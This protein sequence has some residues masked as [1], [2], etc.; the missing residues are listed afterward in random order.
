MKDEFV[1]R[2]NFV[3]SIGKSAIALPF[4]GLRLTAAAEQVRSAAAGEHKQA[5]GPQSG[6]IVLNVRDYGATGDGTTKD[7]L[8]IQQT[9]ERCSVFGGGEV[10]FPAGDYLSG[11]LEL[12]SNVVLRV[13]QGA[14]L[15]GSP[16][17]AD[18]PLAQ[19]RWEGR[20]IKGYIGFISA[21]DAENIG[22]V[23]P[24]RIVGS[25]AVKGRVDRT[26]Q[27]RLPALLEFTNCRNVNVH[28]CY[29]E[30]FGMWSIHPTYCENVTFKN[31]TVKSGA[32]GIDVDSC[33][34]VL[35][36]GCSFDTTDD[37]ISLKSGRG[38]EGNTISR[39]T[40]NV[41]IANCTFNDKT[42]ACIGIGSETSGGIRNVHVDHC[43][44]IGART[45]AIYIK[46]RRGRGAFIED[47]YMNDLDVSGAQQGFLRFN[48]LNSGKQD[49]FMVAGIDGIPTIRNFRFTNIHV[50]GVPVLVDG[51][52]IHPDKP[53]D[54]FTLAN[55]TGTCAKGIS[56]ANIKHADIR[57]IHVT[58]FEGPLLSTCDVT[59][60][61]LGGATKLDAAKLPDPILKPDTPYKLH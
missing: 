18:Y 42:W 30:N 1:E 32:D 43:K 6:S 52:G 44:C 23:G 4:A 59:G 10:T 33:K 24:G 47:I 16:D 45:F 46:S 15:M 41:R 54:G 12:R 60:T 49:E 38:A 7:T 39:P 27:L 25:P 2:R 55:V 21:D 58:G 35:I 51:V 28:D 19:V 29:T 61:G 3:K 14:S 20:W 31:V 22:I 36:D 50:T 17:M 57:N 11:A 13:E 53:L 26:T 56:L 40:E 8:A 9:I 34:N 37:C 5:A 48:I